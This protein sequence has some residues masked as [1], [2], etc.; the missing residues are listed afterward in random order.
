MENDDLIGHTHQE[1]QVL[2]C[3]T[4]KGLP[5][6]YDTNKIPEFIG[7]K[8]YYR[9]DFVIRTNP[10]VIV[11]VD[12]DAHRAYDIHKEVKRLEVI[13]DAFLSNVLFIRVN[14]DR[15]H[16]LDRGKLIA[17]YNK[18]VTYKDYTLPSNRIV[19]DHM[20]YKDDDINRYVKFPQIQLIQR[21]QKIIDAVVIDKEISVISIKPFVSVTNTSCSLS[22]TTEDSIYDM[23]SSISMALP[24][25]C[26]RCNYNTKK[27]VH[28]RSHLMRKIA[29]Q[30]IDDSHNIPRKILL[31]DIQTIIQ[32]RNEKNEANRIHGC[33]CG[34]SYIN[35]SGLSRH[36][37]TCDK[38]EKNTRK[39]MK[40]MMND[41]AQ[42]KKTLNK[43][44]VNGLTI[45]NIQNI[46][47]I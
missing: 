28:L 17:I 40:Q 12:E 7:K 43:S 20:F 45:N 29:C 38:A 15:M 34:K 26:K 4:K 39:S 42:I 41:I 37:K 36:R 25:T 9:P 1:L 30:P 21:D 16:Q 19:V 46:N 5:L 10:V 13:W 11:E 44:G 47:N 8:I 32:E 33:E 22:S 27:I 24:Y 18:V 6:D 14:V 23:D 31:D 35:K 2:A 3:F